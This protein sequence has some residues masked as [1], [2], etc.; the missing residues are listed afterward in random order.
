MNMPSDV[1]YIDTFFSFLTGVIR[2]F[3]ACLSIFG[4]FIRNW[5]AC[6]EKVSFLYAGSYC[7]LTN[8]ERKQDIY[9]SKS[10]LGC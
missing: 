5:S 2:N 1:N 9:I 6:F 7:I 10:K 4:V 8:S 3:S